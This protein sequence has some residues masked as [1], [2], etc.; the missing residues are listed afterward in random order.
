MKVIAAYGYAVLIVP[1][2]ALLGCAQPINAPSKVPSAGPEKAQIED[3]IALAAALQFVRE[4]PLRWPPS[5]P[6]PLRD[7]ETGLS[8]EFVSLRRVAAGTLYKFRESRYVDQ[9]RQLVLTFGPKEQDPLTFELLAMH[10]VWL[11]NER[12]SYW[13]QIAAQRGRDNPRSKKIW[14]KISE[15]LLK[16]ET[17]SP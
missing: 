11:D 12:R 3:A 4:N 2:Y 16:L 5:G 15:D 17:E 10:G 6:Y 7:I 9:R 13:S 14:D 8:S 1:V